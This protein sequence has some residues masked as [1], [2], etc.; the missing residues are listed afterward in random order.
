MAKVVGHRRPGGAGAGDDKGRVEREADFDCGM[1]LVKAIELREGCGQHDIWKRNIP[2]GLERPS[3][4][5][6]RLPKLN[7][8][9]IVVES[10]NQ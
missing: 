4:P 5:R 3:E 2:V 10:P 9:K 6:D 1:R 8:P 7:P